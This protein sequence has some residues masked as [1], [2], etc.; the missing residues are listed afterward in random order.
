MEDILADCILEL[1]SLGASLR[2]ATA[3]AYH[4]LGLDMVHVG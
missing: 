4:E 3:V 2:V 1:M